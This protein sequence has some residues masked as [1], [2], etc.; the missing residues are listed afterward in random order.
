M[1]KF[2]KGAIYEITVKPGSSRQGLDEDRMVLYLYSPPVD[3]KA[4]MELIKFFKKKYKLRVEIL[5]G[6]T[7]RKKLIRVLD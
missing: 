2:K 4:N 5:K 7:S 6:H 3:N 1:V